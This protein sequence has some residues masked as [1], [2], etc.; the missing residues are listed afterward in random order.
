MILYRFIIYC[1]IIPVMMIAWFFSC[2]K[3]YNLLNKKLGIS[4]LNKKKFI[5]QGAAVKPNYLKWTGGC[6]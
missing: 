4:Y 2:D 6:G 3:V 1:D 5:I